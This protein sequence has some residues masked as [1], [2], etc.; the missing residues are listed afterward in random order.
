MS[1]RP[2]DEPIVFGTAIEAMRNSLKD[3]LTPKLR[4]RLK[5]AGVDVEKIRPAYPM[6]TWVDVIRLVAAELVADQP[7]STRYVALGR[8]FMRGFVETGVGFAAHQLGKLIGV[9]RTLMRM[10]RNFKQASNYLETEVTEVGPREL[11]LR[12]FTNQ[13]FLARTTD[14]T[15]LVTDYRRGVL[16]EVLALLGAEGAVEIIDLH[17]DRQDVT[18]KV[19]WK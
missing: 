12:T 11:H 5:Q 9:K 4:D 10:G 3:S 18:F 14:R 15:N 16:Q 13:R 2:A 1:D 6:N 17:V 7:E 8:R 19:T